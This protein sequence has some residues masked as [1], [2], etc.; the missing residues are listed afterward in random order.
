MTQINST[1]PTALKATEKHSHRGFSHL[2]FS[3][4]LVIQ[5][6]LR[7]PKKEQCSLSELAKLIGKHK[8]TIS[9]EIQRGLVEQRNNDYSISLRYHADV[10]QRRYEEHRK[11]S[12]WDGKWEIASEFITAADTIILKEGRSPAQ[13]ASLAMKKEIDPDAPTVCS[14]PYTDIFIK[15]RCSQTYFPF[16]W[17]YAE[18]LR[19]QKAK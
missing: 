15:G 14:R 13:A 4:R 12:K 5:R 10:G 3:E 9:R 17:R 8:S 11:H 1:I 18:S 16:T 7:L 6:N 2:T 19:P